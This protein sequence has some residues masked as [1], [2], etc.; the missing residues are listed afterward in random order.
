MEWLK[1]LIEAALKGKV[2]DE[3]KLGELIAG[4]LESVKKEIGKHFIPKEEFNSKNEDLKDTKKKMDDLQKQVDDLSKSGNDAVKFK[5]D[6][7]KV[8]KE[9]TAYKETAEKRETNRQKTASIERSLREAKASTDAIDLLTSQFDLDKIILDSKGNIVDWDNHLKPIKE[10]RKTLFGEV[11]NETGKPPA[12]GGS[13][14]GGTVTKQQLIDKY[15]EAEKARNVMQMVQLQ[16]Q[17]KN[18]KE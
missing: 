5:E 13:G 9:F 1:Q 16:A 3:G 18:F 14:S 17:I 10:S 15:N 2:S 6:L 12:G 7:E 8:N 11:K 4:V